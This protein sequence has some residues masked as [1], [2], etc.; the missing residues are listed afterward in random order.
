MGKS[1][2]R[3][4]LTGPKMRTACRLDTMTLRWHYVAECLEWWREC[5][6]MALLTR[7]YGFVASE[8]AP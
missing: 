6:F 4:P 1:A 5:R 3:M 8:G 2:C 7:K